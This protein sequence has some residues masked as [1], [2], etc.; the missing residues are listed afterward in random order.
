MAFRKYGT[1]DDQRVTGTEPTQ[2]AEEIRKE[3]SAKPWTEEDERD[4]QGETER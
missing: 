1:S 3:A 4:L 2:G